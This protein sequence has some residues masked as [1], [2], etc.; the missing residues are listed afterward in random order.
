MAKLPCI[1]LSLLLMCPA[2]A[3]AQPDAPAEGFGERDSF[4]L[5]VER[6]FGFVQQKLGEE[7]YDT[8]VESKG[9]FTP[10]WG[11]IGLFD[12][13]DGVTWGALVGFTQLHQG[14]GDGNFGDEGTDLYLIRL[15]PRV[16]F[17]FA[18]DDKI[19]AWLR[20]GP[21]LLLVHSSNDGS[22]DSTSYY[23]AASGEAYLVYTPVEHIGLVAGPVLDVNVFGRDD[24]D[25]KISYGSFGLAAGMFG[26]F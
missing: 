5:S 8:T 16:G 4:V 24:D 17:T 18:K 15:K 3:Y 2:V 10:L 1:A 26:E 9:F 22:D 11:E 21:S 6:S 19:A 23:F 12:V 13:S 20:F 7:D 14:G 25:N